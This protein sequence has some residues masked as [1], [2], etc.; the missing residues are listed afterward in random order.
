MSEGV[1]ILR[2]TGAG[3]RTGTRRCVGAEVDDDALVHCAAI[4]MLRAGESRGKMER[5]GLSV[6]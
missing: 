5:R 3:V 2:T 4:R 1:T 6:D